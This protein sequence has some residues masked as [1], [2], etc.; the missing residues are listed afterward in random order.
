MKC[1]NLMMS[2]IENSPFAPI[3]NELAAA[4]DAASTTGK[5]EETRELLEKAKS[6]LNNHDKPEY[7]P[8]FYSVGTST[9]ILRDD[10]LRK[11][12]AE[13]P[14]TDRILIRNL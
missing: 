1:E 2:K 10:L 4:F 13:N 12:T 6:I 9:T 8:L 7:A 11:S 3:C 5:I 14:Y